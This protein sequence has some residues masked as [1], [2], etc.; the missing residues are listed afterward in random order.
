M[1]CAYYTVRNS[2]VIYYIYSRGRACGR[3]RTGGAR[4][5]DSIIYMYVLRVRVSVAHFPRDIM[6]SCCR[7]L[8]CRALLYVY[9]YIDIVVIGLRSCCCAVLSAVSCWCGLLSAVPLSACFPSCA[10]VML[11]VAV[12]IWCNR[13]TMRCNR[14]SVSGGIVLPCAPSCDSGA[15]YKRLPL[16]WLMV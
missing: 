15:F 8:A 7:V 1:A 13:V 2:P 12:V 4:A 3:A 9:M 6:R 14:F 10:R 5:G 16:Y 11:S